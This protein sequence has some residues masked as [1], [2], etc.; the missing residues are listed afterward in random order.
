MPSLGKVVRS[1]LAAAAAIKGASYNSPQSASYNPPHSSI[2][3]NYTAYNPSANPPVN[4]P[5]NPPAN[6]PSLS[7][8]AYNPHDSHVCSTSDL[9]RNN[10]VAIKG[11]NPALSQ[12]QTNG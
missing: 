5:A 9:T 8:A 10:A 4:P 11:V 3:T 12:T 6:P 2:S 1:A 7:N